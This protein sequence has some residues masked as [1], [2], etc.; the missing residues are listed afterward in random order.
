M[1]MPFPHNHPEW[2]AAKQ[3]KQA[4]WKGNRKKDKATGKR[5]S[6]DAD[7]ASNADPIKLYLSKTFKSALTSKFHLSDQEADLLVNEAEQAVSVGSSTK[8]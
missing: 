4:A 5:K 3:K 2:I 8:G 6:P 7:Q 1:Y